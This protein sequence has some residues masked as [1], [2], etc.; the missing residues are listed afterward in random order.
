MF[1]NFFFHYYRFLME[2]LT[3]QLVYGLELV[4]KDAVSACIQTVGD[5]DP[6]K[7]APD[8]I[9]ALYGLDPVRNCVHAAPDPDSA[10]EVSFL[11]PNFSEIM[12]S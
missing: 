3:G 12:P 6:L 9:R 5:Q 2:Y 10:H 11:T 7:A 4:G 8:T 1:D